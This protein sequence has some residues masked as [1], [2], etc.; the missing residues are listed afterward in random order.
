MSR[1]SQIIDKLIS[2]ENKDKLHQ[3]LVLPLMVELTLHL[4][5]YFIFLIGIYISIIIPLLIIIVILLTQKK[6]L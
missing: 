6:N 5:P 3:H 1:L 4:K 2:S